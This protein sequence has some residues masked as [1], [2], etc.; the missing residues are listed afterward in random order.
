MKQW[1]LRLYTIAG[2]EVFQH[3]YPGRL[4]FQPFF[5]A[6]GKALYQKGISPVAAYQ[7]D[8]CL[9]PAARMRDDESAVAPDYRSA[10]RLAEPATPE[11]QSLRSEAAFLLLALHDNQALYSGYY[12]S[13]PGIDQ[14][15]ARKLEE[16]EHTHHCDWSAYT[17][18]YYQL[19]LLESN[20]VV[21]PRAQHLV[22]Y[23]SLPGWNRQH[24]D[25]LQRIYH[26][27]NQNHLQIRP[28]NWSN[29]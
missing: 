27:R 15:I 21:F 22:D 26:E 24:A 7:L 20:D 12:R 9:W 3:L 2:Q 23:H 14:A 1:L 29:H 4:L 13:S 11:V 18:I 16:L 5:M 8:Y 6:V 10:L 19:E 28:A 25:Y 17:R